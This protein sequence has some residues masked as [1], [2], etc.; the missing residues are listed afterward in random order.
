MGT[1]TYDAFP[2]R[3]SRFENV[4]ALIILK[5]A[6]PWP[7]IARVNYVESVDS[8]VCGKHDVSYFGASFWYIYRIIDIRISMTELRVLVCIDLHLC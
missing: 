4:V 8:A 6:Y 2:V 5:Q 7:L 3:T 1:A